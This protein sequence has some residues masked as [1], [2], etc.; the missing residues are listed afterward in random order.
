M[1]PSPTCLHW[2]CACNKETDWFT[3]WLTAFCCLLL[4]ELI[5]PV[6]VDCQTYVVGA[7]CDKDDLIRFW[8][9]IRCQGH[10][11]VSH[12][13]CPALVAP[14]NFR[15]LVLVLNFLVHC[16]V[17]PNL[18]MHYVCYMF[19]IYL[20]IAWCCV[21]ALAVGSVVSD[22]CC[23]YVRPATEMTTATG[24]LRSESFLEQNTWNFLG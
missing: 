20:L 21:V 15:F 19:F 10:I 9:Q 3:E 13:R 12:R 2:P 18:T 8:G 6:S 14:I 4:F 16:T 5:S 22:V 17:E 23:F 1:N 24:K 7:S 11:T